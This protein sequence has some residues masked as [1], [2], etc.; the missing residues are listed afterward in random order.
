V[1]GGI[2]KGGKVEMEK[3][4]E[5]TREEKGGEDRYRGAVGKVKYLC[6]TNVN[7]RAIVMK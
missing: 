2:Q 3:K 6:W 5:N 7:I 4:K 1:G